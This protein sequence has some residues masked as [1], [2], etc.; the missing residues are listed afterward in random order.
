MLSFEPNIVFIDDKP[1]EVKGIIELYREEGFGVKYF[2]ADPFEGDDPPRN[3]FTNVNLIYLDLYYSDNFDAEICAGWIDSLVPKNSF[4]ILVIWSRDTQHE[5]DVLKELS[6]LD[7]TPFA[8]FCETKNDDY[9]NLDNS[10]NWETL[11]QKIDLELSKSPELIELAFW[12]K[13][14][15]HSS[16]TIIGHLTKD[17]KLEENPKDLE[18]KLKKIILGHGGTYLLGEG[19]AIKKREVLLEALDNI[20]NSNSK[21]TR[22]IQEISEENKESLYQ[23]EEF[24]VVETDSKLNSWF[25]FKLKD[26]Q[27]SDDS[28]QPGLISYFNNPSLRKNYT[29]LTDPTISKY[30]HFQKE[31]AE[32]EIDLIDIAMVISR[33]CDIAQNKFGRNLKLL[34]GLLITNPVR[35]RNKFKGKDTKP[36]SIKVYDHLYFNTD[37]KDCTIIFD[38]RYIFSLPPDIFHER[39]N[40]FKSFNKELLSELQVEYSA[41]SSRL[42]IT[43]II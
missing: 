17:I 13:S 24:P 21:S 31:D 42:G 20:L 41:Y 26:Y 15:V 27:D 11:K 19:D 25:H 4:Y 34:S 6:V 9:R 35:N 38:F 43:Q 33:P 14:I 23:I 28:I 1:E 39:F 37:L 30:L 22:P 2:K 32:N 7:K 10:F 8:V 12:K 3:V 36:V 29:L 5:E 40:K 16:N 18:K